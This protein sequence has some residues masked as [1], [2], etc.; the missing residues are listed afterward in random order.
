MT[1]PCPSQS[2]TLALAL[3]ASTLVACNREDLAGTPR[4]P[5]V[6]PK[7]PEDPC[8][9]PPPASKDVKVK[10]NEVMVENTKTIADENGKFPPWVELYNPT[11]E[12]VNLGE[13]GQQGGGGGAILSDECGQIAKQSL[14]GEMGQRV[15]AHGNLRG[16]Y[17]PRGRVSYS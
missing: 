8:K 17:E 4:P 13:M 7:P 2:R 5:K 3:L 11:D 6:A 15:G 9:P 1:S 10:I 14:I 12:E 16:R